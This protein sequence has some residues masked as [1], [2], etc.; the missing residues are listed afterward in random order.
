[1]VVWK[2]PLFHLYLKVDS[3]WMSDAPFEAANSLQSP[4]SVEQ[5]LEAAPPY[6]ILRAASL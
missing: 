1:M 3:H 2:I 6:W 4:T 5:S